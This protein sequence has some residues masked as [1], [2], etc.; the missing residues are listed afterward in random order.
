VDFHPTSV[1]AN[2]PV[3]PVGTIFTS[4]ATSTP[5]T[6]AALF[7]VS[8]ASTNSVGAEAKFTVYF[9]ATLKFDP[10][11]MVTPLT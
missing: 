11:P 9:C 3:R 4:I 5:A 8:T 2:A 10:D 7:V 6:L 1:S